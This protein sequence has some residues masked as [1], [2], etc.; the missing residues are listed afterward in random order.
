VDGGEGDFDVD[1][2][3]GFG[4]IGGG[5]RFL[6]SADT[7][8]LIVISFTCCKQSFASKITD[9]RSLPIIPTILVNIL[10]NRF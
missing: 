8:H 4:G 1:N 9:E 7:E 5:E 10:L 6:L 3:E 2:L